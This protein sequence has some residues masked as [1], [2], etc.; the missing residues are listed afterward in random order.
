MHELPQKLHAKL[1]I[2]NCFCFLKK[3][4]IENN[5][6]T[7]DEMRELRIVRKS[8]SF[9]TNRKKNKRFLFNDDELLFWLN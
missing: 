6:R 3:V 4:K 5:R 1:N 7:L 8:D 9:D 2:K